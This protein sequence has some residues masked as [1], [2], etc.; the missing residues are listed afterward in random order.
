MDLNSYFKSMYDDDN[1]ERMTRKYGDKYR[2]VKSIYPNVYKLP[3]NE[4]REMI[5]IARWQGDTLED[6]K[7]LLNQYVQK[8]EPTWQKTYFAPVQETKAV[9]ENP[10]ASL[11]FDGQNLSWMENGEAVTSWPAMSGDPAYQCRTYQHKKGLGPLPEGRYRVPINELQHWDD[12]SSYDKFKSQYISLGPWPK[13]PESWGKH[14]VW[15]HPDENDAAT[16]SN[17]AGRSGLAIHGGATPGSNGCI[18]L[19]DHMDE[20]NDKFQKYNQDLDLEVAYPKDCW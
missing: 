5:D 19:T 12:L 20:F 16:M 2:L 10:R 7:R 6:G 14:R 18:D 8:N 11:R 3:E 15:L 9:S 1:D 4:V 17:M 13:G